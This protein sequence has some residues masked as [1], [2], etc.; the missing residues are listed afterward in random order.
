MVSTY[1]HYIH[2]TNST[3]IFNG[4]EKSFFFNSQVKLITDLNFYYYLNYSFYSSKDNF[5]QSGFLN[6]FLP[7][8]T[9]N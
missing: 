9:N 3:K 1:N 7:N 5:L 8:R 6:T 2:I 4:Y